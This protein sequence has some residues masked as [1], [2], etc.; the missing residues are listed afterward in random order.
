MLPDEG[1]DV[2]IEMNK[3]P[4]NIRDDEFIITVVTGSV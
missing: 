4:A 2:I 1:N 3:I